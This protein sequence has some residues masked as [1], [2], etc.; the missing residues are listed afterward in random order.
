MLVRLNSYMCSSRLGVVSRWW[1]PDRGLHVLAEM[2]GW[3]TG[4]TPYQIRSHSGQRWVVEE[5]VSYDQQPES[6]RPD[7][8]TPAETYLLRVTGPLPLRGGSG[9]QFIVL[10]N[11]GTG[12]GWYMVPG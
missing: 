2:H 9:S 11:F 10:R 1:D 12:A 8:V 3:A 7:D 6:F 5:V 4:K